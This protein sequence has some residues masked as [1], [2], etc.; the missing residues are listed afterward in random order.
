[1]RLLVS[2]LALF[3]CI[4]AI[5]SCNSSDGKT[6]ADAI[7]DEDYPQ[8]V[9]HNVSMI[10][11]DSGVIKYRIEAPTWER[12]ETGDAYDRF[13]DSVL[14]EQI[15]S[16]FVVHTSL[17]ADTAYRYESKNLVHLIDN[18]RAVSEK[19]ERFFSDD[20]YLDMKH[21]SVYSESDIR[22]ER[23]DNIIIGKGFHSNGNF[24][25]YTILQTSGIFPVRETPRD[26]LL[27]ASAS[28]SAEAEEAFE[29]ESSYA[30]TDENPE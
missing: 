8:M 26:T 7:L 14:V 13:P 29:S 4:S 25:R 24:T 22:I 17:R 1:M 15:D 23:E 19:G 18:V 30:P 12:F 2:L 27:Q 10:I 6:A 11:S 16:L 5:V 28:P 9:T 3:L 21:D 20:L